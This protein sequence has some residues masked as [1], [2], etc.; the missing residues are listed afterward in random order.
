[1]C[2]DIDGTGCHNK[3]D[4]KAKSDLSTKKEWKFIFRLENNL[5]NKYYREFY[6]KYK[7]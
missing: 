1:M 5:R 3:W 6:P 4:T 2:F 7:K